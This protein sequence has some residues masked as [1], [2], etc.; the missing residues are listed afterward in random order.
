ML[1]QLLLATLIAVPICYHFALIVGAAT[2]P[3]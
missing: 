1:R 2:Y 3:G